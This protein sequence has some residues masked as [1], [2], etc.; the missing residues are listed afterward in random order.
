MEGL[1]KI[2]LEALRSHNHGSPITLSIG[3]ITC[4]G[5][6]FTVDEL[7]KRADALM[8]SAKSQGKN[9]VEYEVQTGEEPSYTGG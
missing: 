5:C 4:E 1:R 9:A 8:Y 7:I 6:Q 2:L 3:A